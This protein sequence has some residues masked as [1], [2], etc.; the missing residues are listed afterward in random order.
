MAHV[1]GPGNVHAGDSLVMVP[2][3]VFTLQHKKKNTFL[4]CK[5]CKKIFFVIA[6]THIEMDV[7][8]SNFN[9]NCM[10]TV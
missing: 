10:I 6:E 2:K 9:Q 1:G 4:Y 7:T 3:E 8:S 5:E